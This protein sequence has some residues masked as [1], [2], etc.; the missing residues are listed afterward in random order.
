MP[1]ATSMKT[2]VRRRQDR[3][4]QKRGRDVSSNHLQPHRLHWARMHRIPVLLSGR[5]A[6]LKQL[7]LMI[8][9]AQS[10]STRYCT[11]QSTQ[12]DIKTSIFGKELDKKVLQYLTTAVFVQSLLKALAMRQGP[13]LPC[14]QRWVWLG[15][16]SLSH[17]PGISPRFYLGLPWIRS[18]ENCKGLG[19]W[20]EMQVNSRGKPRKSWAVRPPR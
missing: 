12:A 4:T 1:P 8:T 2:P 7:L 20:G 6:I 16:C 10:H 14:F 19:W 17:T 18:H 11:A 13:Y 15:H 9:T 5:T 3:R